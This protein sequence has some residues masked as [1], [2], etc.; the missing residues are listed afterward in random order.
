MALIE[1]GLCVVRYD[2]EAGKGDHKHQ[3]EV[4]VEYV[5]STL[6]ALRKIFGPMSQTT[7]REAQHE[8]RNDRHLE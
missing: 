3:G 2:N 6:A 8:H 7:E 4:E 5:F 1:R